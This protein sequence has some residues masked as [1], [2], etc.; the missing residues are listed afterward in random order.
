MKK[1]DHI[2]GPGDPLDVILPL[3][4]DQEV[5]DYFGKQV[6]TNDED[7]KKAC[8]ELSQL[9]DLNPELGSPEGDRLEILADLIVAYEEIR[10]PI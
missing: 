1:A 10:W 7:H 9:M 6:I 3:D 4:T 5:A 8:E 2:E